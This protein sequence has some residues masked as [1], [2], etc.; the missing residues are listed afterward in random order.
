MPET[1]YSNEELHINC[2]STL[3]VTNLSEITSSTFSD[4]GVVCFKV[5]LSCSKSESTASEVIEQ[6][7]GNS[8]PQEPVSCRF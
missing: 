6:R 4:R 1:F 8:R 3:T 5:R 2:I 7:Q